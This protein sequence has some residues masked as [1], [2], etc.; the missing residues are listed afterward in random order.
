M[1]KYE[2][3]IG[4]MRVGMTIL[5]GRGDAPCHMPV[6][7]FKEAFRNEVFHNKS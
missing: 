1:T 7:G 4:A 3:K 5:A 6:T 2:H